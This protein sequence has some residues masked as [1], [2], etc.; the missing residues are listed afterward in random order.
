MMRTTSRAVT[1]WILTCLLSG[2]G[3]GAVDAL[4]EQAEQ[5]NLP[6]D[7]R[8]IARAMPEIRDRAL[9]RLSRAE[10]AN[11][12]AVIGLVRLTGTIRYLEVGKQIDTTSLPRVRRAW[13]APD[14]NLAERFAGLYASIPDPDLRLRMVH[15]SLEN[16]D[17]RTVELFLRTSWETSPPDR[18]PE[19]AE[20]ISGLLHLADPAADDDGGVASA[21]EGFT[22]ADRMQRQSRM[23]DLLQAWAVPTLMA[24]WKGEGVPEEAVPRMRYILRAHRLEP[25]GAAFP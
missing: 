6:A 21:W 2:C 15:A 19:L 14:E 17:V 11:E 13:V 1:G 22:E 24:T 9:D 23:G 10:P 8:V 3:G 18:R 4:L 5:N 16:L 12:D 25:P 20:G 7:D